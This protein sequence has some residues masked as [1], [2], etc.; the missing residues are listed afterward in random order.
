MVW[1]VCMAYCLVRFFSFSRR[2]S[3][4]F[5]EEVPYFLNTTPPLSSFVSEGCRESW[6]LGSRGRGPILPYLMHL[7][8]FGFVCGCSG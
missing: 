8:Q 7:G 6:S 1:S 3:S 2:L 5:W 4:E